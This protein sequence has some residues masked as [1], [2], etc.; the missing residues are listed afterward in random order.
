M[1]IKIVPAMNLIMITISNP[2]IA[3]PGPNVSVLY[4]NCQGFIPFGELGKT[5]PHLDVTNVLEFQA[6]I[7]ETKPDIVVL[8]EIWLQKC[9]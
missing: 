4:H 6:C 7:A 2:G 3:N 1:I 8:N 9:I 5:N